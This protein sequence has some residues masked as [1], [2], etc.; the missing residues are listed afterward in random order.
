MRLWN[1][2]FSRNK[3]FHLSLIDHQE[4]VAIFI[5]FGLTN[6]PLLLLANYHQCIL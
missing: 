4:D 3:R 1:G 2:V 6:L 5:L